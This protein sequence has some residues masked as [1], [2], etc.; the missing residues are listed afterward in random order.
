MKGNQI[1]L[2]AK[3]EGSPAY[4]SFCEAGHLAKISI[5]EHGLAVGLNFLHA[6]EE[7]RKQIAEGLPVHFLLRIILQ[8]RTVAEAV[9]ILVELPR[10]DGANFM[11]GDETGV[12]ANVEISPSAVQCLG[13][14][15]I[16]TRAGVVT[17]ANDFESGLPCSAKPPRSKRLLAITD[18]KRLWSREDIFEAL[19]DHG[20][21]ES[22]C[23][24][25]SGPGSCA[26]IVSVV[27]EPKERAVW[28]RDGV[29]CERKEQIRYTVE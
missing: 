4:V 29:P 10:G 8:A 9:R 28:V 12:I 14:P 26:S 3:P 5:N 23:S 2:K 21:G 6:P 7:E 15:V 19:T 22:I 11:M 24:H 27:L 17:H 1:I 20:R 25:S 16:G 18:Q 13:P